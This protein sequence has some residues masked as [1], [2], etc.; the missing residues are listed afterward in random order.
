MKASFVTPLTSTR[1]EPPSLPFSSTAASELAE[2][3]VPD[4]EA[5]LLCRL[6]AASVDF[7]DINAKSSK[8]EHMLAGIP[9]VGQMHAPSNQFRTVSNTVES[10]FTSA[11]VA[12]TSNSKENVKK[13]N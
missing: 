6:E 5:S 9:I 8:M 3:A 4:Q 7:E 1:Q 11:F 13:F 2:S 10:S 12:V